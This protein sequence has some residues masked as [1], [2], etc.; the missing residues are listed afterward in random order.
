M[1]YTFHFSDDTTETRI[2]G[3]AKM[4]RSVREDGITVERWDGTKLEIFY[5]PPHSIV[6]VSRRA[7]L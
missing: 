3:T 4:L 1:R 5:Y 7:E 2:M 6:K